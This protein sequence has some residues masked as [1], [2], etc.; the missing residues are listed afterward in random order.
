MRIEQFI[1]ANPTQI[2]KLEESPAA[3]SE[4]EKISQIFEE[5]S[6][7]CQGNEE[8]E[9]YYGE[10]VE[11]CYD[12]ATIVCEYEK[13]AED[14]QQGKLSYDEFGEELESIE[15]R[16]SAVH[17][18]TIDSFNIMSRLMAKNGLDN[19]WIGPL[20]NGGRVAYGNFAIKKTMADVLSNNNNQL[21]KKEG[22]NE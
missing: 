20:S 3:S 22:Q 21:N 19:S 9:K 7:A 5:I 6:L 4:L 8:L 11:S 1:S 14:F 18:R 15:P 16:R 10:M 13:I 12:Y 2:K 17:N